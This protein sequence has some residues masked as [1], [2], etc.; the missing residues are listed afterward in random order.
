MG[1]SWAWEGTGAGGRGADAQTATLVR[2]FSFLR[3]SCTRGMCLSGFFLQVTDVHPKSNSSWLDTHK[4]GT[5]W[6]ISG[7]ARLVPLEP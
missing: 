6:P 7:L 1:E 5:Y 3:D 4:K 2:A